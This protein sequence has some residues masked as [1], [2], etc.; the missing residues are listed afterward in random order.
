MATDR[1]A[2]APGRMAVV[3]EWFGP[4]GGSEKVFA[5][6][7]LAFPDADLWALDVAAECGRQLAGREIR[8]TPLDRISRID[9]RRAASLPFMPLAWQLVANERYDVVLSSSHAFSRWFRGARTARRHLS[10]VHTPVRYVWF[11]ETDPRGADDHLLARPARAAL[12]RLD[13]LSLRWTDALAANSRATAA[14][15]DEVY[16][17]PSTVIHP[18]VDVDHH[19]LGPVLGDD[20]RGADETAKRLLLSG[21]PF[22]LAASRFVAYKQLDLAI[23]AAALAGLPLVVAGAGEDDG[24]LRA[25]VGR[26]TVG[27]WHAPSDDSLRDL[28][29]GA[30]VLIF[31]GLEDFGIVPVEAMACGTP[32]VGRASGGMLDTVVDGVTGRLLPDATPETIADAVRELVAAPPPPEKLREHVLRFSCQR[33]RS[34]LVDWVEAETRG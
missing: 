7:A 25:E 17:R 29:R 6:M 1:R 22:V 33:F 31:P 20:L 13:R 23:D 3:H 10:Y 27:F 16:G 30:A 8:T 4:R 12:R 15:I 24:R 2:H 11:P 34:E 26:A 9:Q 28:Y 21:E 32:V 18:P 14:R 5:E 19:T